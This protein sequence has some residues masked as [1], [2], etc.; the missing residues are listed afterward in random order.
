M[1]LFHTC[2]SSMEEINRNCSCF[3]WPE[4]QAKVFRQL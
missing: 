3:G 1:P 2:V 4:C